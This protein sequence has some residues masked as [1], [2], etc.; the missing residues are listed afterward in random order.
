MGSLPKFFP[1]I[2]SL[3]EHDVNTVQLKTI[4]LKAF[5]IGDKIMVPIIVRLSPK[6]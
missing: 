5:A 6:T 4:I 2:I 3:I 1:A